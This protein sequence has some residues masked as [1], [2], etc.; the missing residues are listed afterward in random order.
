[1]VVTPTMPLPSWLEGKKLNKIE[2]N[3]ANKDGLL[4]GS[5]IEEFARVGWENVDETDLQLRLKWYGMFWRPKTPGLFMLRLRVPNGVLNIKQLRTI[6]SIVARY[7]TSGS[8]DITTRQNIQLRGV[9]LEDLPDILQR[10]K[11]V[12]LSTIQSGFDNPRN[13]TGNPIAGIDPE[14]IVDT[15]PY[16]L[17]LQNFLTNNVGGN[18]E[19]SNLPRKWNTAVAG[20]RDNFLLHNDI[21]FHPVEREGV[22]GFG[23]WIGGVLSSKHSS[24]RKACL[25][26]TSPSPR[27]EL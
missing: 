13:V 25:L 23:V 6:G 9:L 17:E 10:L 20:S 24:A 14:E 12:G 22:M 3:K 4:V 1:M 8:A 21:V 5:E 26:Y 15:R 11:A 18:P 16:T 7:G 2:Q 19:F 27:D